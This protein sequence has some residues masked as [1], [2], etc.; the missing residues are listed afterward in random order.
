[1][2]DSEHTTPIIVTIPI[3]MVIT[4]ITVLRHAGARIAFISPT[5]IGPFLDSGRSRTQAGGVSGPC[6]P[7]TLRCA[8]VGLDHGRFH[9]RITRFST[10]VVRAC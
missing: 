1:M 3:T 5:I 7:C 9:T 6:R 2:N 10:N 8:Q 4:A